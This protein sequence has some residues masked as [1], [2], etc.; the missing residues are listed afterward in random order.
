MR[1]RRH[2]LRDFGKMQPHR[3][4]VA[5]R[6]D[7]PGAGALS[8]TDSTENVRR[9]GALIARRRWT[10]A[11]LSP[12]TGDF[13]LL[14]D[15]SLVAEPNLYRFASCFACGDVVDDGGEIFLKMATASAFWA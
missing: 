8:G 13:V 7:Q 11:S 6:Q 15:P 9:R 1:T 12:A 4:G 10:G 14:S 5:E 3:L 2:Y